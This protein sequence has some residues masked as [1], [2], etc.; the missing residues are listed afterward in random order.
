MVRK[1]GKGSDVWWALERQK[2][3]FL[4]RNESCDCFKVLTD[5]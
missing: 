3:S 1:D 4:L 2:D 5:L